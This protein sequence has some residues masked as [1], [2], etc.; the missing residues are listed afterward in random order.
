MYTADDCL[1]EIT[2]LLGEIEQETEKLFEKPT[3]NEG[4]I[5]GRHA[6]IREIKKRIAA[7]RRQEAIK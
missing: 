4:L 6:V 1:R 7:I 5:R 2:E 3:E